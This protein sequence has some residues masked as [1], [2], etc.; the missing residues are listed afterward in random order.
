MKEA[1]EGN[2]NINQLAKESKERLKELKTINR[3]CEILGQN[4]QADEAFQKLAAILPLGWQYSD[5]AVARIIFDGKQFTSP[6]FR[7]TKWSL[8]QTFETFD[9]RRGSIEIYY[10]KEF[11]VA[12]EGPFIRE[13]RNLINNLARMIEG[14][15]H[16]IQGIEN[17]YITNERLKELACINNTS[18]ILRQGKPI[19]ETLQQIALILPEA[20]QYPEFTAAKITWGEQIFPTVNYKETPWVIKQSFETIDGKNGSIEVVYLKPFPKLDEGPFLEEERHLINNLAVMIAGYLN[21]EQGKKIIS[22]SRVE[23]I[24]TDEKTKPQVQRRHLLQKFLNKNNDTRDIYHDL[25]MFKVKEILL[26]ANLY[27]AYSIEREGQ[28]SEHM[29]DE[30]HQLNLTSVPRITGVSA[31]DEVF[32]QLRSKHFDLIILMVGIDKKTPVTL[33]QQIKEEFPYIP[34]FVL[35]NNNR[36]I[37]HFEKQ[38]SELQSIDRVFSWNGNSSIFFAMIKHVEDKI[39]VVND[40][41]VGMVRVILLV[42]DSP[43]YYSRYLPLLYN[44][45]MAQTKRIIDDVN[46]DELYKVLRMRARPKILLATNYEEALTIFNN[47]KDYLLCLISDVEFKRSNEM[48]EQ[49][50]FRL[51]KLIKS[52]ISDLPTVIQS[53]NEKNSAQAYDLKASFINKDSETLEQDFKSFITHYLGFGNFIYRN[54]HGAKIAVAKS[55]KEFEHYLRTIPDESLIYHAKKNHF[56]LWLM[57]RG[58]IQVAKVINPQKVSD[59]RNP[60]SIRAYLINVIQKF[61]NEQDK[62]KLIPFDKAAINDESNVVYLSQGSLGGKGRG[63][64]FI[65][66]LI[67]NF[68]FGKYIPNINIRVPKTSVIGTEEF[69]YFMERN[70]LHDKVYGE[71]DYEKIKK[72][73]IN[74]RLSSSLTKKLKIFVDVIRRPIAVRSSGLFEDSLMQ[75][76][77]GIF[78]TFILP[79]NHPDIKIRL[80]QLSNAI[81]LVF[82]SVFSKTAR[83]YI[84]AVN[85]KIEEEKMAV[86]LQ[87]VVGNEYSGYY[88]PHISGVAQSYNYYPVS[89]MKPEEGFA[90]IAIGLGKYV[91]EGEKAY[92]FSPKYPAIEINSPKDQYKNSQ[93]HFFAVNLKKQEVDLMEGDMAGL[94]ILDIDEAE[95]HGTL[96][97]CAS[98]YDPENNTI[99]PGLLKPGPRIVNF[100]NI[101][102]YNYIPLA[103]TIDVVLDLVQEAMGSPVE[104]EFAVDLNK[105]EQNNASFYLL[106]IKP[107]LGNVDDYEIDM[108]EM[109][110]ENMILF[111]DKA[112]G[113][114]LIEGVSDIIYIDTEAF[115]KSKTMEMATEIEQLNA[116]MAKENKK[117]VLIGPGRWGTRDPWIGI[118]VNWPQISK[119]CVIVETSYHGYPLDASSGSHF[120]HNVTT[121]NVG[122]FSVQPELSHGYIRYELLDKQQ[123]KRRTHFFKHVEFEKP[124]LIKMDGRKRIAVV[125]LQD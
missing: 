81:K 13:E 71:E 60:D 116:Q 24:K 36:D 93:V 25:M 20:W 5:Q 44:I 52:Q 98:V 64:A 113:N 59:F 114:G 58:E 82:A 17:R 9:H 7:E 87:E 95:M 16:K 69:E 123:P 94:K 50:G 110:D 85:Y 75:P 101:L 105:D 108:S 103:K 67:Y 97:H 55:L 43:K 66:T 48:D 51:T 12:D 77:A 76:F 73:F 49:A 21:S 14:Y 8:K 26:V 111:S 34:I 11:P 120:F 28:F 104:I 124:L 115:D 118:P 78:E 40:T 62:G 106:Q 83:D 29:L 57:A 70:H 88:Y 102:K 117:Y 112:M 79:N 100:A 86:V 45:V 1:N 38:R 122:Y 31:G 42:E 39:N 68:D 54:K 6:D 47:F 107:L 125:S 72:F 96:K 56:S 109:K 41:K 46:T 99:S 121:M 37:Q 61:R 18:S 92:R 35:L 84:R 91:V 63:L 27:E 2:S 33:S 89:H 90:L 30:Y 15:I 65:N 4:N 23:Q 74:G 80:T 3:T 53:S 19:E 10:L 32:E 119:A 22:K